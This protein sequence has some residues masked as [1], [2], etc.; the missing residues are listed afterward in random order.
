MSLGFKDGS[1]YEK[2]IEILSKYWKQ[3]N[4]EKK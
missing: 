2:Y 4:I 3:K 1:K